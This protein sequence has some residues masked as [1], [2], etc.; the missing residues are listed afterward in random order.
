MK[1]NRL[2][3]RVWAK[4]LAYFLLTASVLTLLLSVACAGFA[5]EMQV[6]TENLPGLKYDQFRATTSSIT[7]STATGGRR[8]SRRT[9]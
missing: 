5:W 8:S 9:A 3:S 7:C 4:V 1:T 2:S 6:Y